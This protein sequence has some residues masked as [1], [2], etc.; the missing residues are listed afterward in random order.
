MNRVQ[1]PRG[2]RNCRTPVV[3]YEDEVSVDARSSY[4]LI[5]QVRAALGRLIHQLAAKVVPRL[6]RAPLTSTGPVGVLIPFDTEDEAIAIA[7][8]TELGLAAGLWSQDASRVHR[9]AR[10]LQ[11]GTV[12]INDWH[13]QAVEVP[14]GGFKR[15]GIGRERG[16]QAIRSYMQSKSVTQMLI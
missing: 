7:N 2:R 6:P 10:R 14:M 4:W 9:V 3:S 11:A 1:Q 5:G 16:L 12:Y 8:D 15:S 13:G